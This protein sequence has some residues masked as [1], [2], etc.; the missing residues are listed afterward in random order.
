MPL[1][2]INLDTNEVE[3]ISKG[4]SAR[5]FTSVDEGTHTAHEDHTADAL[6]EKK[7]IKLAKKKS[8]QIAEKELETLRKSLDE[9]EE[10]DKDKKKE[11]EDTDINTDTE[12]SDVEEPE[13]EE[14]E[15]E[16]EGF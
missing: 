9:G 6:H 15:E 3:S 2:R 4:Q 12:E 14:D 1:L 8:K 16:D 10:K 7:M 11:G 13:E 5:I